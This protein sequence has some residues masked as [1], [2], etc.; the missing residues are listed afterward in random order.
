MS[1]LRIGLVVAALLLAIGCSMTP[2]QKAEDQKAIQQEINLREENAPR[3][4]VR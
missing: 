2:E 4:M 3:P 1:H